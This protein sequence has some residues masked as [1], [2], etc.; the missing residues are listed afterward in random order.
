M[1]R[2]RREIGAIRP[3]ACLWGLSPLVETKHIAKAILGPVLLSAPPDDQLAE[4]SWS[5]ERLAQKTC[6]LSP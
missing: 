3:P 4:P 6:W 5:R 2:A 1:S